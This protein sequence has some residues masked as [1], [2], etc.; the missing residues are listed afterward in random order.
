MDY[1]GKPKNKPSHMQSNHFLTRV[2][3]LFNG[4]RTGPLINGARKMAIHMQKNKAVP[5]P[6]TIYK[7]TSELVKDLKL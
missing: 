1:S 3:R 5:L 2:P 7:I 4:A 6:N